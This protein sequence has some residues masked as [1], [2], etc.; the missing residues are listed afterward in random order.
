MFVNKSWKKVGCEFLISFY[1]DLWEKCIQLSFNLVLLKMFLQQKKLN[2]NKRS[3]LD[4]NK[5]RREKIREKCVWH[6][7]EW[8]HYDGLRKNQ[9]ANRIYYSQFIKQKLWNNEPKVTTV[10]HEVSISRLAMH[11]IHDM[12]CAAMFWKN[13]QWFALNGIKIICTM[14]N[15]S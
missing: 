6:A 14:W 12:L 13:L 10:L 4:K 2:E 11:I 15:V 7:C 9:S 1:L 5:S 3:L 8:R